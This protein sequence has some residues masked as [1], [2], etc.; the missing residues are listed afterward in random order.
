MVS[1]HV[2]S[3]LLF[4]FATV[5]LSP[6]YSAQL[7]AQQPQWS[8]DL[9]Q[10]WLQ[11]W[12]LPH[13]TPDVDREAQQR[14]MQ[15]LNRN[16]VVVFSA[17]YCTWCRRAKQL[18]RNHRIRYTDVELDTRADGDRLHAV[19]VRMTRQSTVPS[20]FIDGRFIG[21]YTDLVRALRTHALDG[22]PRHRWA[23]WGS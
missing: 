19:L 21:G 14:V 13:L 22:L 5:S 10:G 18:L 23:W 12:V 9:F 4:L 20:I 7:T 3:A 16:S 6:S 1:L 2:F 11:D 15:L 8:L 17:T